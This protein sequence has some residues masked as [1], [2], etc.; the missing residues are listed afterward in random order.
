MTFSSNPTKSTRHVAIET[1]LS[2]TPLSIHYCGVRSA[3]IKA[4]DISTN[5]RR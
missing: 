5:G 2:K 4:Y 3:N 1:E